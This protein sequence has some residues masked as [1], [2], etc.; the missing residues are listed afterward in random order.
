[1]ADVSRPD[2]KD[3][4]NFKKYQRLQAAQALQERNQQL[5]DFNQARELEA[6]QD[7]AVE[8][9]NEPTYDDREIPD[10]LKKAA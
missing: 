5:A 7:A 6:A 8:A 10:T 2:K 4:A 1:M 3:R 9:A